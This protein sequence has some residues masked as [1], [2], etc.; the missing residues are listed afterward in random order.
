[1]KKDNPWIIVG[2]VLL[3]A[4]VFFFARNLSVASANDH[5]YHAY[6][7]TF[8]VSSGWGTSGD[9]VNCKQ[10]VNDDSVENQTIGSDFQTY[11]Y[12][13]QCSFGPGVSI[14]IPSLDIT[15]YSE[16]DIYRSGSVTV[17]SKANTAS[18]AST[19][20]GINVQ[21]PNNPTFQQAL[22]QNGIVSVGRGGSAT[23][24]LDVIRIVKSNGQTIVYSNPE[25]PSGY[26]LDPSIKTITFGI[27]GGSDGTVQGSIN[28][29]KIVLVPLPSAAPAPAPYQAPP[30]VTPPVQTPGPVITQAPPAITPPVSSAPPQLSWWQSF[31]NWILSLFAR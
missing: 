31:I 23:V 25:A 5:L 2:I 21:G 17:N 24:N 16:V 18:A 10:V 27:S 4:I 13:S 15:N 8:I 3:L 1:M 30:V 20:T 12:N 28:V 19:I 29:G 11:N 26:V 6:G 14:S 7:Q 22:S 9:L